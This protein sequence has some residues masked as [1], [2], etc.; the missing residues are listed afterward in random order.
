MESNSESIEGNDIDK[1]RHLQ[2]SL[3]AS[4]YNV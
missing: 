4:I 2:I 3:A 1:N